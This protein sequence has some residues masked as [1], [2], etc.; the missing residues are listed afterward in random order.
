MPPNE[1]TPEDV[2]R[3]E[4][5]IRKLTEARKKDNRAREEIAV[6][7]GKEFN[8]LNSE[9]DLL[10]EQKNKLQ[11]SAKMYTEL[12]Q[13]ARDAYEEGKDQA[14]AV[15]AAIEIKINK[16]EELE[17]LNEK[18]QE[19]LTE[20]KELQ[21]QSTGSILENVK[22]LKKQHQASTRVTQKQLEQQKSTKTLSKDLQ[23]SIKSIGGVNKGTSSLSKGLAKAVTG[24]INF[25]SMATD[26]A[27]GLKGMLH[28]LNL[29]RIALA[30]A[31]EKA[32]EMEGLASELR[33]ATGAGEEMTAAFYASHTATATL[34]VTAVESS[35]NIKALYMNFAGF[36]NMSQGAQVQL[37]NLAG[38]LKYLGVSAEDL[39]DSQEFLQMGM[40][41]S[42]NE[43]V[44]TTYDFMAMGKALKIPP[45]IIMKDFRKAQGVMSQ[46]GK[47]VGMR[48]FKKLSA[49]VK[50]TGAEMNTLLGIAGGF[51]TFDDAADK[52][53]SLNSVL[54]HVVFDTYEM[55][56][57]NEA[58]R[59][60]ILKAGLESVGKNWKDMDKYERRTYAGI[61][62]ASTDE[63]SKVM[64]ANTEG[65]VDMGNAATGAEGSLG[66]ITAQAQGAMGPMDLLNAIMQGL[67]PIVK[68][69]GA[70]IMGMLHGVL[71]LVKDIRPVIMWFSNAL[72]G[73]IEM[74]MPTQDGLAGG[75]R[76]KF[77]WLFNLPDLLVEG[78]EAVGQ[79]IIKL[80]RRILVA[81]FG[82]EMGNKIA[83]IFSKMFGVAMKI[84][85]TLVKVFKGLGKILMKP[86]QMMWKV[87]G[88]IFGL[89]WDAVMLVVDGITWVVDLISKAVDGAAE[90]IDD[91]A[92]LPATAGKM[93]DDTIDE[94]V[95]E[96]VQDAAGWAGR[97]LTVPGLAMQAG[98]YFGFAEGGYVDK[99]TLGLVGEAGGEYILP[100]SN[101]LGIL[102]DISDTSPGPEGPESVVNIIGSGIS[103][104]FKSIGAT[105]SSIF[106]PATEDLGGG[107]WSIIEAPF[108]AI[109]A[110][111]DDEEAT[112]ATLAEESPIGAVEADRLH[113]AEENKKIEAI[114]KDMTAPVAEGGGGQ[115]MD[116]YTKTLLEKVTAPTSTADA[117]SAAFRM[118]GTIGG[119]E[120]FD[121]QL[122]AAGVAPTAQPPSAEEAGKMLN[123]KK[124]A[125]IAK[126]QAEI[127]AFA[128]TRGYTN[129]AHMGWD[130][131]INEKEAEIEKLKS[132]KWQAPPPATESTKQ[133][134]ILQVDGE[135]LGRI[136]YEGYLK[137]RLQ[138]AVES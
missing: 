26:M 78:I 108:K 75:L 51:D 128:D 49:Q 94:Y 96:T 122:T 44:Q 130:G 33:A 84:I 8:L 101:V 121:E 2:A 71:G 53:G 15:E 138:P 110:L 56:G 91:V 62:G 83:D 50:A 18:Q 93:V 47:E 31:F 105:I 125:E 52:V 74:F 76:K 37:T 127:D 1:P 54:G 46:F 123:A 120:W 103:S 43:A 55:V 106:G 99:P 95:P 117:P 3:L 57:A 97:W 134:V 68:P 61:I 81:V 39:A 135:T 6:A 38:T 45:K 67:V 60:E 35:K 124:D 42:Q 73:I 77:E 115:P 4:E 118:P 133:E 85:K 23:G 11:Q 64:L 80:G 82:D 70:L 36:S 28:P 29:L 109:G 100:E 32:W 21:E 136:I 87:V 17:K 48:V 131:G 41:M 90:F 98:E 58:E 107:L 40:G 89:I 86:F 137:G 112:A 22:A 14:E 132:E 119:A 13:A 30:A 104:L 16:L 12:Q 27:G 114:L 19:Q 20:L 88:P 72:G 129:L 5:A 79:V 116:R 113:R 92:E 59:I 126:I 24:G 34:G 63:M 102:K 65:M 111:F 7:M 69:L 9:I 10:E 25:K 66:A